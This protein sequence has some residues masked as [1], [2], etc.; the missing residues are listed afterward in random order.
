MVVSRSKA[1]NVINM[2]VVCVCLFVNL[3]ACAFGLF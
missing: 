1:F 3:L 2:F